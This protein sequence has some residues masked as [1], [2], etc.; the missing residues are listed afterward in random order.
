MW[1]V[2]HQKGPK[3]GQQQNKMEHHQVQLMTMYQWNKDEED[4]IEKKKKNLY[5]F[6]NVDNQHATWMNQ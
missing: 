5:Y 2:C 4:L 6:S 3:R 1:Q